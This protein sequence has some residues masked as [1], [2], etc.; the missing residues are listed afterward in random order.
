MCGKKE[1]KSPGKKSPVTS[2]Q[3]SVGS[4]D[5]G[6]ALSRLRAQGTKRGEG[7]RRQGSWVGRDRDGETL[8]EVGGRESL[9]GRNAKA[10]S[11]KE[12]RLEFPIFDIRIQP[13]QLQKNSFS[14]Y[15]NPWN[16]TG[17]PSG[18]YH[19]YRNLSEGFLLHQKTILP[20]TS[21]CQRPPWSNNPPLGLCEEKIMVS[22][23]RSWLNISGCGTQACS[24]LQ[25]RVYWIGS[26]TSQIWEGIWIVFKTPREQLKFSKNITG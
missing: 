4:G 20:P 1:L 16:I 7:L 5:Q 9:T 24:C 21:P 3:R 14:F 17:L 15:E 8:G 2:L 12:A 22:T 19:S 23:I 26:S 25:V 18:L 6:K 11:L 10:G 13:P